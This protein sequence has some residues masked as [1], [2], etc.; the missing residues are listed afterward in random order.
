MARQY[1]HQAEDQRQFAVV[2]AAEIEPHGER[3]ERLGLGD[4]GVI[5][6][7]VGAA[8]VAQQR[9]GKQHVVGQ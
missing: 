1:R 2:G 4:L 8:A 5:L 6:A 3:V 9:P 7:V